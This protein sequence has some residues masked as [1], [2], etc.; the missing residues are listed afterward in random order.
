MSDT[1][2]IRRDSMSRLSPGTSVETSR[3]F[4]EDQYGH[5]AIHYSMQQGMRAREVLKRIQALR[6]AVGFYPLAHPSVSDNAVALARALGTFHNEGVE[7]QLAFYSGDILLGGQL[8][9][10]ESVEFDQ[11]LQELNAVGVGSLV[12]APGVDAD[13]LLR[14]AVVL[15]A[16]P[17]EAEA[18]GGM[19]AMVRE[20]GVPHVHVGRVFFAEEVG[21]YEEGT[22]VKNAVATAV[23][24]VKD[25]DD[26]IERGHGLNA[27][28]IRGAVSSLVQAVL[29]DCDSMLQL[30]TLRNYDEYAS[31]HSVNVAVLSLALASMLTEDAQFL[32]ALATGAMMLDVGRAAVGKEIVDKAGELTADEWEAMKRH[33]VLGAE[34]VAT[35][36]GIGKAGL[37]IVLEHHMRYDGAGY[38]ARVTE[39]RQNLASRIVAVADCYDAMTSRRSYSAPRAQDEAM[40]RLVADAGSALDPTIVRLFVDM[41]GMYPP[42]TV[43]RLTTGQIAIVLHPTAGAPFKP[44]V[45]MIAAPNGQ[46]IDAVD[47]LL[48]ERDDLGVE[49]TLDPE[50]LKIQI[51]DFI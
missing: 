12:F 41:M 30:A 48:A 11:L 25:I 32:S 6:R 7:V 38:P 16:E 14:A 51:D 13:E 22:L 42:R 46:L 5:A 35:M 19:A 29:S 43:V 44:T 36:P 21:D 23:D 45:R 31:Y 10:A 8:L 4:A 2:G 27:D 26:S 20:A 18:A 40:N 50:L 9:A 24:V 3:S 47:I 1:G 33:S 15:G 49:S 28:R 39:R 17:S 37:V 34:M